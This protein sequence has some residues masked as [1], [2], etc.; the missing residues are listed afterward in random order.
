[1]PDTYITI[2]GY[3]DAKAYWVIDKDD[4]AYM[5]WEDPPL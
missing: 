3:F 5:E 2:S 1:M 4:E